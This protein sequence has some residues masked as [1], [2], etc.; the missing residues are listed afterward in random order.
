MDKKRSSRG[1][2]ALEKILAED[3]SGEVA[4]ALEKCISTFNILGLLGI[5]G[6]EYKEDLDKGNIT[7]EEYEKLLRDLMKDVK[8]RLKKNN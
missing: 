8:S 1:R 4:E 6:K 2:K 5:K 7:K 3:D